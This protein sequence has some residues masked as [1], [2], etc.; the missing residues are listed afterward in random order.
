MMSV[1]MIS[2]ND[3]GAMITEKHSS[4]TVF[5]CEFFEISSILLLYVLFSFNFLLKLFNLLQNIQVLQ[6]SK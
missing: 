3:K 5:N 4:P 2:T 1:K 6:I